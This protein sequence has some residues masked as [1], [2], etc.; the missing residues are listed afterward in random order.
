MLVQS[1]VAGDSRVLREAA[2][3]A[4]VGHEV[5]VVGRDVPAVFTAPPGVRVDSVGPGT[6]LRSGAGPL[7]ARRPLPRRLAL[8]RWLFLPEHRSRVESAWERAA[9][10]V[11]DQDR[12]EVVHAHDFNTLALGAEIAGRTGARLVYDTHE[13]WF[14]RPRLN[15][16]T[17]LRTWRGRRLERRLGGRADAVLTVGEGVAEALR[18]AY[19]WTHVHV[20]RNTFD[21]LPTDTEP[22]LPRRPRGLLYAGRVAPYRELETLLAAAPGLDPLQVTVA[23]P[24]DDSF[25]A[26][27]EWT[28]IEL[29]PN[30]SVSE[31]DA[32]LRAAGLALVSH[33]DRWANHRLALPNKLFH[34]VRVGV[35][36]VATDVHEL[37]R[38]VTTSRLGVLYRPGDAA[39]L[40]RAVR[41]IYDRYDEFRA[42]VAA[43]AD[44]LSWPRDAARLR[45]VYTDLALPD[46][47]A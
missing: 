19:G 40:V 12:P 2:A 16:P 34:A 32:R 1:P 37:R 24:A 3:L 4:D 8:A 15:R 14:G 13:L 25:V 10:A 17:P 5:R 22:P 20:V 29:L 42:A 6:G 46:R 36:V 26:R 9:R 41:E 7:G 45:Q 11:V 43:A 47:L 23:G 18:H 28:G 44:E 31:V 33:S 27:T 30:L 39:D 21:L 38:V 35:P